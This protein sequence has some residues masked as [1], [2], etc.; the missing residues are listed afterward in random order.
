M[1]IKKYK[2]DDKRIFQMYEQWIKNKNAGICLGRYVDNKEYRRVAIYGYGACGELLY[3]ELKGFVDYCFAIDKNAWRIN[4]NG[5]QVFY[6]QDAPKNVDVLIVTVPMEFE[7]IKL[8]LEKKFECPII[9][10][11]EVIN[12]VEGFA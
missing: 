9:S 2:V 11:E 5:I 1:R 3:E 8:E 7:E 6:E 12:D 4:A 10:L